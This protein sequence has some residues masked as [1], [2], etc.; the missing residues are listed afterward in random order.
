MTYTRKQIEKI[1]GTDKAKPL[2]E[3]LL[4][5]FHEGEELTLAEEE[6]ACSILSILRNDKGAYQFNIRGLDGCKNHRFNRTYLLYAH[7]LD[8]KGNIWDYNGHIS[9][10]NKQNDVDFLVKEYAEWKAAINGKKTG[11]KLLSYVIDETQ[12]QLKM[13]SKYCLANG[14]PDDEEAYG[15]KSIFLHSKFVFLLVKEFY[16]DFGKEDILINWYGNQVLIDQFCFVHTLFRHYASGVKDYQTGKSYHFDQSILYKDL[17]EF[18]IRFVKSFGKN[19]P[20][21]AFNG[22]SIDLVFRRKKY[23]MWF[24]PITIFKE[25]AGYD[26]LRLQTFYPVEQLRDKMRLNKLKKV[27]INRRVT[28]LINP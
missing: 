18:L 6:Y 15:E 1:R 22:K 24:R 27:K 11:D 17:P 12:H 23:S 21:T 25:G 7:D 5:R 26:Y 2:I 4:Q 20:R 9:N 14:I 8:G 3:E 19:N 16:Q 28:F 10:A 13:H